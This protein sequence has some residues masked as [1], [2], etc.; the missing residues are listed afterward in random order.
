MPT[1]TGKSRLVSRTSAETLSSISVSVRR[2]I[3]AT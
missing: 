2:A 3:R 1:A